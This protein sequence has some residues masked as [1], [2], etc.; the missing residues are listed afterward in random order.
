[1]ES[2]ARMLNWKSYTMANINKTKNKSHDIPAAIIDQI[3]E[4]NRCDMDLYE[5][6][7]SLRT[8]RIKN[9]NND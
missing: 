8:R 1:M 2:L 6:A 3:K 5:K 7:L 9:Y 4:L